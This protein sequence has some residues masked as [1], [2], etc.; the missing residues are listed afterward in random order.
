[1]TTS[2]TG[3]TVVS[4]YGTNAA[5]DVWMWSI[6]TAS[7]VMSETLTYDDMGNIRTLTRDTGSPI[8]Y[9]YN[10]DNKSNRW[11]TLT[12]GLT[13]TF[14]YDLNGNATKDRTDMLFTYNHLNLPKTPIGGGRSVS[15]QYDAMGTKL[16]KQATVNGIDIEQDYIGSIEYSKVGTAATKIERIA[17]EEG[18]LLNSEGSYS[19]H[20]NLTDHL[21]NVRAVIKREGSSTVPSVVQKQDYYPF[22][23]TRSIATSV[24]NKYLYNGKEMQSDLNLG[25][26]SLGGSYVLEGQLDYGARFYDAEIGRWNVIDPMADKYQ[27]YSPYNYAL[28]DPVGKLDPNGMWTR[29]AGGWKSTSDP[30]EITEFMNQSQGMTKTDNNSYSI[31]DPPNEYKYNDKTG[32]YDFVS[33]K[34]GNQYDIL[35]HENASFTINNYAGG[36]RF[37]PGAWLVKRQLASGALEDAN[38]IIDVGLGVGTLS[39]KLIGNLV[40]RNASKGVHL[41]Y[42]GI[43]AAGKV[44]YVGITGREA[45]VRFGEHLDAIG[46]GRELLQY[47]VVKGATRLSEIQARIWEQALINQYGLSRNGGQLLNRIN[48]IA[49]KNW[50]Q[51]G[52][53]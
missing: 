48:S 46:T 16:K 3:H 32:E 37:G 20:Y 35:H 39:Y 30:E 43:D 5:D 49:P 25:T 27:S 26:H 23:K 8:T 31:G 51:Y 29:M 53:K 41:V 42:E 15:Y 4:D 18:F 9:T 21:G 47:Q 2:T 24:N 38:W 40:A 22:G 50:L 6:N 19:Y 12:G 45:T 36:A 7:T 28:N 17:T 13:G 14:T 1:M 34:G 52:I 33:T 44:R 11:L 10:N